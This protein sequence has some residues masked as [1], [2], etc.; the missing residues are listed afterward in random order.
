MSM[1]SWVVALLLVVAVGSPLVAAA[2]LPDPTWIAGMYDDGDADSVLALVWEEA[3]AVMPPPRE[4]PELHPSPV[5]PA[6][7][8]PAPIAVSLVPADSRSPPQR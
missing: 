5:P 1:R 4:I 3:P 2:C 8:M 6:P 7:A